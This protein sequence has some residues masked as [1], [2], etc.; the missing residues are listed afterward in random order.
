MTVSYLVFRRI[1]A[2]IFRDYCHIFKAQQGFLWLSEWTETLAQFSSS[3]MAVPGKHQKKTWFARHI[4]CNMYTKTCHTWGETHYFGYPVSI[5]NFGCL[6]IPSTNNIISLSLLLSQLRCQPGPGEAAIISDSDSFFK[7]NRVFIWDVLDWPMKIY[8]TEESVS[9]FCGLNACDSLW[10][11]RSLLCIRFT[12]F[13]QV[14]RE[15]RR[16]W[17]QF[18]TAL[19]RNW[20]AGSAACWIQLGPISWGIFLFEVMN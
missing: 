15:L 17:C 12:S 2:C 7:D 3:Y 18:T 8:E 10:V 13:A 9:P 20:K 6:P 16:V 11:A 5:S 1:N 14:F 19:P 4:P